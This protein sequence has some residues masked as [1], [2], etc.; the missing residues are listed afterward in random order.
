MTRAQRAHDLADLSASF[1]DF[2]VNSLPR[3][4]ESAVWLVR[5]AVRLYFVKLNKARGDPQRNASFFSPS[6]NA[7]HSLGGDWEEHDA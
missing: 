2:T 4:I 3:R 5:Y 7:G 1:P 6:G